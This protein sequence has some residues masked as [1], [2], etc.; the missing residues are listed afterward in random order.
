MNEQ[1]LANKIA[2]HLDEAADQLPPS[3]VYRLRAARE[4]ALAHAREPALTH[5]GVGVLAGG[6]GWLSSPRALMRVAGLILIIFLL[7]YWQRLQQPQPPAEYADI[8][9][10]L[11]TDDLPV[12]AYLDEG[13]EVW[14]YH[15][16]S[17]AD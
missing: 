13:F 1:D 7:V 6:T 14:L 4:T 12:T 17:S 9:A 5:A 15:H 16:P 2:R 11:L 10:A 3:T 8:D